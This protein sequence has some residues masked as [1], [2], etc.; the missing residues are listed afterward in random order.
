M[1]K[2]QDKETGGRK[3]T[4]NSE[5]KIENLI[6]LP[7]KDSPYLQYKDL[8]DYKLQGYG[9]E[10]HQEPTPGRGA[11]AGSTDA[12][13]PSGAPSTTDVINRQGVP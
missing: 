13:T 1:E 4:E 7:M 12:P 11:G 9:T 6:G 8:E 2:N 5:K 3:A 10:G